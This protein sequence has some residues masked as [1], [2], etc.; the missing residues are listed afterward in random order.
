MCSA[1][2]FLSCNESDLAEKEMKKFKPVETGRID[3]TVFAV[4]GKISNMY[5][6]Q[7]DDGDYIAFD[8]G[9]NKTDV[10][11]GL[12][13]LGIAAGSVGAVF[14]THSD[15]DHIDGFSLFENATVYISE[16]EVPVIKGI[17]E[18]KKGKKEKADIGNF[19]TLS[20][21]ETLQF[22]NS[23]VRI[24]NSPGH[25]PGSAAYLV[26]GTLLF[27]GDTIANTD[28]TLCVFPEVFNT[29]HSM[30]VESLRK[31]SELSD[32]STILTPHHGVI[33]DAQKAFAEW[34]ASMEAA[35]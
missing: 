28:G 25:T 22:G 15:W 35:D 12:E 8:T 19:R 10:S 24:L 20:D 21:N 13:E 26:N 9:D 11:K 17:A 3:D 29:D 1:A 32:A 30:T 18:R 14:L 4:R 7:Y 27:S 2:I 23:S 5:L 16:K 6:V 31:L 34:K 33:F